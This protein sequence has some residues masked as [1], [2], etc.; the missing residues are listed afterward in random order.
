VYLAQFP[1]GSTGDT[2]ISDLVAS[3]NP[4][5]DEKVKTALETSIADIEAHPTTFEQLIPGD[6]D[7]PGRVAL[8]TSIEALE[9]QGEL[10]AQVAKQLGVRITIEV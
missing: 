10:L 6:D 5:L 7:E 3:V 8:L 9:K 2:S 1:D 4:K